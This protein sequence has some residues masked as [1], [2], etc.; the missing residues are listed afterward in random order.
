MRTY[1]LDASLEWIHTHIV[2]CTIGEGKKTT[3]RKEEK[4]KNGKGSS[5]EQN[6]IND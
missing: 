2:I 6:E 4:K 1:N 5:R 3:Q